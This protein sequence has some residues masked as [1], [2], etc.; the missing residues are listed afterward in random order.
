MRP[1]VLEVLTT[2]P[3]PSPPAFARSRQCAHTRCVHRNVPRRWTL[4]T[5][6]HSSAVMFKMMRGRTGAALF[7][8]APIQPPGSGPVPSQSPPTSLTTTRALSAAARRASPRPIPRPA[9]VTTTIFPSTTPERYPQ[10][11]LPVPVGRFSYRRSVGSPRHRGAVGYRPFGP[12]WDDDARGRTTG[13]G[14]GPQGRGRLRRRPV[15]PGGERLHHREERGDGGDRPI[16]VRRHRHPR[17]G[18]RVL[19][20]RRHGPGRGPGRGGADRGPGRGDRPGRLAP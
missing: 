8:R 6:S 18:R 20:V 2:A 1:L 7:T 12:R 5:A 4:I 15:G 9:P 3:A 19:G 11:H 13:G 16:Q 17:P 14:G 10:P